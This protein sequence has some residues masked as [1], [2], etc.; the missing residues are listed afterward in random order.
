MKVG[1]SHLRRSGAFAAAAAAMG[2]VIALGVVCSTGS[3]ALAVNQI[4][5]SPSDGAVLETSP[6]AV[7]ITFDQAIG[8]AFQMQIA[9]N[10]NVPVTPGARLTT[11]QKSLVLVLQD[12]PLPKG[13]CNVAWTVKGLSDPGTAR[14]S[15]SFTIQQDTVITDASGTATDGSTVTPST[16]AASSSNEVGSGGSNLKGPL[17]L[18]RLLSTIAI[19]SL[20]GGLV[21][22]TVA[23][24]EG[25]EYILTI[26]FMRYAWIVAVVM[27]WLMI[28]CV[29]AQIRGDGFTHALIPTNWKDLSDSTPGLALLARMMLVTAAGWVAVRPERVIDPTTQ[30]AGLA[31]PGLA[32]ATLGFSRT[33]GELAVAGYAA[34][35]VHAVAVSVWFGGLVLLA[36]VVLAGPGEDDLVH[37][38]R[39]FGKIATPAMLFTVLSGG[40]QLYRLDRGHLL[41]TT[42][43]RLLLLKLVP[44]LAM[45]FVSVATR[46]FVHARLA[47]AESLSAAL[48]GRL[49]RAVGM[50]AVIGV[51]VLG[52]TS[53]MLSYQPARLFV[54]AKAPTEFSF[55]QDFGDATGRLDATISVGPG[56]VGKN[57]V[58]VVIRKPVG[59]ISNFTVRFNPPANAAVSPVVMTIVQFPA[60]VTGWYL[61]PE[62][63]VPLLAPGT[64]AVEF[65]VTSAEGTFKLG[66]SLNIVAVDAASDTV[67]AVSIPVVTSPPT[68]TTMPATTIP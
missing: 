6:T 13:S 55:V 35:A 26:R 28:A 30:L 61:P 64:W 21:L 33:G 9:C 54:A 44:V 29:V 51:V 5:T 47:R 48:A 49:R 31:I 67:P 25:V 3:R 18:F 43:G 8:S 40:V 15:F 12:T 34:G 45:I 50:E 66:A 46:Q 32:I 4:A 22:I 56:T 37:A 7:S 10:G 1:L 14:G 23:W 17:G 24:P 2:L 62:D 58:L 53:W 57:A 68:T 36:R 65:V 52:I 19:A 11:D 42:H 41:D 63:G 39:G 59:N 27:T 60:G 16:A 38:V 20:F